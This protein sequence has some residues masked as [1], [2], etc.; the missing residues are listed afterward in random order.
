METK[1]WYFTLA[2]NQGG[3]GCVK[4]AGSDYGHAGERMCAAYGLNWAFQ[5]ESLEKV[6][7]LDREVLEIIE[8]I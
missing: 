3:P 4:V 2:E 7:P 5:Y 8:L 6:H 1:Y